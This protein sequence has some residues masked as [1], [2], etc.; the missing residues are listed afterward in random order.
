MSPSV[1]SSLSANPSASW[2]MG[3]QPD[4]VAVA[5]GASQPILYVEFRKDGARSIRG[6]GGPSLKSRRFVD[7]A[8]C[9][10]HV[11]SRA[12]GGVS[13]VGVAQ[14]ADIS[15]FLRP[16]PFRTPIA[17]STCFGDVFEKVRSDYVE[18]PAG[19]EAGRDRHQRHADLRSIRIRA[20]WTPR[21]SGHA[22][23][24]RGEF[25]GLGIEVTQEDAS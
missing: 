15:A 10:S 8:Q 2:A 5:I 14:K 16:P 1:N 20:T 3:P 11:S 4:R 23:Q 21:A 25:G 17:A 24:T 6:R 9:Q 18:K 22:G 13:S 12:V 19:P 7:D